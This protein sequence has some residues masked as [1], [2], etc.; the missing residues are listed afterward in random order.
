MYVCVQNGDSTG[1]YRGFDVE[2]IVELVY[3]CIHICTMSCM[4]VLLVLILLITIFSITLIP[5]SQATASGK[6]QRVIKLADDLEKV[7]KL[8]FLKPSL[9]LHVGN[10]HLCEC[11]C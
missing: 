11:V 3:T 1:K 5:P 9:T 8:V 6:V 10:I 2:L 7:N 4:F